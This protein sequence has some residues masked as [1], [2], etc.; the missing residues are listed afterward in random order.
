MIDCVVDFTSIT[1]K[2]LQEFTIPIEWTF[3]Y[4]GLVHGVAGW[5]D[6]HLA[7]HVLSTD[8]NATRTH[9]QQVRFL[10]KEPLAVNAY[11]TVYGWLHLKINDQ[12]S[13]DLYC[14]LV[15][16]EK[17]LLSAPGSQEPLE[18]R[19]ITGFFRKRHDF[20]RLHEQTYYQEPYPMDYSRPEI[21]GMY[22]PELEM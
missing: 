10:L 8:P 18:Q 4:T 1:M 7:G 14:E 13:Y 20:W 3:P 11:E 15:V 17:E 12:R 16:N 22:I 5:F 19:T 6:I 9:W 2:Q 21:N